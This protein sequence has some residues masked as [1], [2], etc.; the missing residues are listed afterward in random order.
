MARF[1]TGLD[2]NVRL[3]VVVSI[4]PSNDG[5]WSAERLEALAPAGVRIA[6]LIVYG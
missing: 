4:F 3:T 1:S 5:C 6:V 2:E